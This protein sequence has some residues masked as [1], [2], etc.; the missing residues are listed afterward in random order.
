[1]ATYT[2]HG[3]TIEVKPVANLSKAEVRLFFCFLTKKAGS[4]SEKK[5]RKFQAYFEMGT[6]P[7]EM[8]MITKKGDQAFCIREVDSGYYTLY[9]SENEECALCCRVKKI[10]EKV[11]R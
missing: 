9:I 11:K 4:F 1:M 8:G 10:V 5:Q 3:R 2:E 6:M 7:K